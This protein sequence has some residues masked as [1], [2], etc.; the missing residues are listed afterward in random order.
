MPSYCA[1][2]I[3]GRRCQPWSGGDA[4]NEKTLRTLE[5]DKIVSRLAG[6]TSFDPG[7]ERAL[8][9]RPS[10]DYDEVVRRQRIT[11]EARRLRRLK[12]G[13]GLGGAHDIRVAV[14]KAALG[15][16]LDPSELL[17]IHTT[18]LAVRSLRGAIT[19]LAA[20][21]PA[22][23]DIAKPMEDLGDLIDEIGSSINQRGEVIDSAS[24]ALG[25]LR[26]Q[27]GITHDRLTQR[28][29][30]LLADAVGRGVAQ[31]PLI[32]QRDGR[33]VIPIKADYRGSMRGIV[34]DVSSSGATVFVEPLVA[35][36]LGNAWR[37]AQIEE[38]R[39]V[40]RILR[41]LSGLVGEDAPDLELDVGALA[42]LDLA[43]AKARL[44]E[45]W[46]AN[47]LPYDGPGQAWLARGPAELRLVDARH[48]LLT[49]EAVPIG[50][51]VGGA[52]RVLLITGPNTGGKTVA[53]KTAG[54]LALMAQAGLPVPAHQGTRMPVFDNVFAD[55]GDEQS[56]EQSLSTFSSHMSNI[57][58]IL[59][60]A[61][62][63]T[64]VLLDE[65]GAGTDPIEGAALARAVVEHLLGAEASVVAT[66]HHGELKAFA[67]ATAGVMNSSVEFD[68][69]TLAPTYRLTIGLPGR[70]NALAIAQRLGMDASIVARAREAVAP[71]Q[72]QVENLLL[73]I[74]QDRDEALEAQ[75]RER[76]AAHEAE[77]IRRQLADR[78]DAVELE[79]EALLASTRHEVDQELAEAREQLREARRRLEREERERA[80]L[81]IATAA[82]SKV[83]EGL[84]RINRHEV[85]RRRRPES[86]RR[87][88][89]LSLESMQPGDR[90]WIRGLAQPGEA[91]SVPDDRDQIEV[92][93]GPLRTR[94]KSSQLERIERPSSSAPRVTISLAPRPAGGPLP[95][96]IEVRGQRVDEA[97]P[98]VEEY[99]E[100]AYRAG[101]ASVRIV[102]GKGTGTLRRVVREY[103][104]SS[105]LVTA[106]ETAHP[107]EGGEG[108]TV[109]HMAV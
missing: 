33:Y 87:S 34:H 24:A 103:L 53:L 39:E 91:L 75:R 104:S 94:I 12:P 40:E 82:M 101:A 19:R 23:A 72:R 79:R 30:S 26:S 17:D 3:P 69:E 52:F 58:T 61:R 10:S 107:A 36:E 49:G 45:I 22:L 46:R 14:H 32:T 73:Q 80:D 62:P 35:V 77:E 99:L 16:V 109:V 13:I 74:Q 96:Q 60:E 86:V 4:L 76:L 108:V 105:P 48:P 29:N 41:R 25:H 67:H 65:L 88:A 31:E 43:F 2:T 50:L 68:T 11:A 7:Q 9:L 102:H 83:E 100:D 57:I 95:A 78:L 6:L 93:L 56:I 21:A 51:E 84:K 38:Q 85:Q 5:Y 15:G 63:N 71:E 97:M 89:G 27:V 28:L 20:Q 18:L 1:P 64:L 70:S 37:E 44:G 106:F 47:E 81:V 92:L 55:I 54:L 59:Q 8:A 90:I 98:R 42:E 66:T